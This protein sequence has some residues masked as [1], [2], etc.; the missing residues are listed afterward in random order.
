MGE[1]TGPEYL[2]I[3]YLNKDNI[4]K[5]EIEKHSS[6]CGNLYNQIRMFEGS[7]YIQVKADRELS[8]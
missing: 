2:R 7:Q 5:I 4:N 8:Y 3:L 6:R 1:Q